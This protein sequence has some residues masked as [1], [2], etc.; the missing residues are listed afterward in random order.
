MNEDVIERFSLAMNTVDFWTCRKQTE[1]I[2]NKE[3]QIMHT[4]QHSL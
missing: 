1:T 2:S 4:N 3:R